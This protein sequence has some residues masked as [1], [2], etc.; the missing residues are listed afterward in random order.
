MRTKLVFEER[1]ICMWLSFLKDRNVLRTFSRKIKWW[2]NLNASDYNIESWVNCSKHDV[3]F[4]L[5]IKSYSTRMVS[6]RQYLRRWIYSTL[7]NASKDK[8]SLHHQSSVLSLQWWACGGIKKQLK[9]LTLLNPKW[10]NPLNEV[11]QNHITFAL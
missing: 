8:T 7:E 10:E 2:W 4:I 9:M 1:W 11:L 6:L 5:I 3:I